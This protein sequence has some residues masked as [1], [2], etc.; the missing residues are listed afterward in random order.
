MGRPVAALHGV[1]V[2]AADAHAL[3]VEG[4]L[5]APPRD[6]A[7]RWYHAWALERRDGARR[8]SALESGDA[9]AEVE[10]GD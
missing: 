7:L 2:Y 6:H 8:E 4:I 10:A 3:F 9:G 5:G 1:G